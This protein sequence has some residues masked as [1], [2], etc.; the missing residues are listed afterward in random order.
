MRI[1]ANGSAN[2]DSPM[3][4]DFYFF[5]GNGRSGYV[6]G[7]EFADKQLTRQWRI[8]SSFYW[9]RSANQLLLLLPMRV[10]GAGGGTGR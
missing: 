1:A 8:L 7:F 10:H 5:L 4:C 2:G 6:R 9:N 3:N